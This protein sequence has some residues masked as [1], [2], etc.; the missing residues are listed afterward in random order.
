MEFTAR[1]AVKSATAAY[2]LVLKRPTVGKCIAGG[3]TTASTDTDIAAGARVTLRIDGQRIGPC[4]GGTY[5]GTVY[6][7]QNDG[8]GPSRAVQAQPELLP[9]GNFVPV[10]RFTFTEP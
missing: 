3:L 6:Y 5:S 10:G 1:V 8:T 4:P 7:A 9:L 2:V